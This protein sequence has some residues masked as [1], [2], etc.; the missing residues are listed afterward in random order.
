MQSPRKI[1]CCTELGRESPSGG[2]PVYPRA[3]KLFRRTALRNPPLREGKA[4]VVPALNSNRRFHST[5]LANVANSS[6]L[7]V[8]PWDVSRIAKQAIKFM[9]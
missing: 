5:G 3:G 9:S 6:V 7:F 1:E 4:R 2:E 8:R